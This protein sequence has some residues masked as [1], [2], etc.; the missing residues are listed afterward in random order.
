MSGLSGLIGRLW[1]RLAGTETA[2]RVSI[3]TAA[4]FTITLGS[5]VV[6]GVPLLVGLGALSLL[7]LWLLPGGSRQYLVRRLFRV[8]G[9]MFVAMAIV[10]FLVH[11]YPDAGRQD[12]T[13]LVPAMERYVAWIGDL[14]AGEMG[15]TTYSETVEE[16]LS[17]T[18]PVSMQLLVYSQLLA[19]AIAIP[20]ALLGAQFRGK[21]VDVV[22]RAIGLLGLAV[23]IFVSGLIFIYIFAVGD[24]DMFGLSWGIQILPFGRYTPLGEGLLPHLK[25]MLLPSITLALTTAATYLVLLRAEMLQQ[26]LSDHVQLARSKGISPAR[27]VRTHALRPAAPTMVAAIGAQS[28]LV[29]GNMLIIERVFTL[30]GFGDYVLIAIGR[31]DV[32]A[33][34]GA[35]FVAA[36]ILA[37]VNLFADALLL[38]VDPRLTR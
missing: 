2:R 7:G 4:A 38:A 10:W 21:L 3:V 9:T 30:P 16:G 36:A 14:V 15:D 11:N 31:R 20:G 33:I 27:I 23:P 8:G 13:G 34:A 22:F 19:L 12:A 37:V 6:G 18:I 5:V 26:L 32:L 25:S 29:L 24:I 35:L 1:Y 17:R 28:G